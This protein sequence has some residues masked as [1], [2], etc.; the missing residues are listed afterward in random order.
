MKTPDD[1][2]L[3]RLFREGLNNP[4][5]N[6]AFREE[7]WEAMEELLDEK[8]RKDR[9]II[10]LYWLSGSI[11][12]MLV[13]FF[14]W[15]LLKPVALVKNN[16][17]KVSIRK[18]TSIENTENK[19]DLPGKNLKNSSEKATGPSHLAIN[20]K[21]IYTDK[22]SIKESKK[23]ADQAKDVTDKT[24]MASGKQSN[25]TNSKNHET[26]VPFIKQ[27]NIGTNNLAV[28]EASSTHK[29]K[30]VLA[31]DQLNSASQFYVDKRSIDSKST[32]LTA[33]QAKNNFTDSTTRLNV[34]PKTTDLL[35]NIKA[36]AKTKIPA[37]ATFKMQPRFSLAILTAPDV[38][39]VSSFTGAKVGTNA[40][41][42]LS[43]QLTRKW[44]INTGAV[45][46]AKPYEIGM[47]QYQSAA[48]YWGKQGQVAVNCKVLD[49]PVNLNYQVFSKNRNSFAAGAGLSSYF[50]LRENY[51][52]YYTD[53]T[54]Y[55]RNIVNQNKHILG[56]LNLNATYQRQVNPSFNLIVQP[57]LKLPLTPIGYERINLQSAGIAIGVG[58]NIS[59]FKPK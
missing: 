53:N 21:K 34:M 37:K 35:A 20:K 29:N 5:R 14:G 45:Y 19:A 43:I 31:Y 50:M 9:G 33:S 1:N 22:N 2:D 41:L 24:L 57:Y 28:N 32:E 12:A 30:T 17:A 54:S 44:S 38:N 8:P 15:A 42:Q 13:L 36:I 26:R 55:S 59:L 40:G 18:K 56:V 6:A 10:W 58:W 23:Q 46:A 25:K 11:A 27:K 48:T 49:I 51:D 47:Q 4:D 39:G 7:N 52:F 16:T 3:D